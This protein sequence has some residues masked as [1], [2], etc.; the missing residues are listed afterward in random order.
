M[1][2]FH[3]TGVLCV[4]AAL[5]KL[6]MVLLTVVQLFSSPDAD[7]IFSCWCLVRAELKR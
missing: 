7:L 5:H 4:C 1:F 3:H 6:Q 2:D